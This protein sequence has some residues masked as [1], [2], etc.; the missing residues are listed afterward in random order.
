MPRLHAT[1]ASSNQMCLEQMLRPHLQIRCP[2]NQCHGNMFKSDVPGNNTTAT[3]SNP[4][5]LE[6]LPRR[7]VRIQYYV[8]SQRHSHVFKSHV[9]V[10]TATAICKYICSEK[11]P[12]QHVQILCARNRCQSN[13]FKSDASKLYATATL[14]HTH[15]YNMLCFASFRRNG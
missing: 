14:S 2:Q 8:Q 9:L 10:I 1:A 11:V 15:V 5:C 4:M 3:C 7:N 12:K 6:S 13:M